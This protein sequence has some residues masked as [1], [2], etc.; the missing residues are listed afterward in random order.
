MAKLVTLS[1][2]SR[3]AVDYPSPINPYDYFGLSPR[4]RRTHYIIFE[5]PVADTATV[6]LGPRHP[7]SD[8]TGY[9]NPLDVR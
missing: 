2:I 8:S 9:T 5:I 7:F 1:E 6:L 4:R 3:T